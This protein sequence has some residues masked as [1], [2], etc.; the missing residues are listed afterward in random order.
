[1]H[2]FYIMTNL[3]IKPPLWLKEFRD[4]YEPYPPHVTLKYGTYFQQEDLPTIESLLSSLAASNPPFTLTFTSFLFGQ[5]EKG[6]SIMIE[7]TPSLRLKELQ[8]T[9]VQEFSRFGQIVYPS[10]KAFDDVFKPHISIARHLT[11]MQF[12]QAKKELPGKIALQGRLTELQLDLFQTEDRKKLT[13]VKTKKYPFE[14][15]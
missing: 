13:R 2:V 4:K 9:I 7:A 10:N 11:D 14:A 8:A 3:I 15:V 5:T 6:K 1:M 12:T